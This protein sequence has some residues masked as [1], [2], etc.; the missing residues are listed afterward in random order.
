MGL[1]LKKIVKGVKKVAK[2]VVKPVGKVL[3]KG[4]S[5]VGNFVPGPLGSALKV[6]GSVLQGNNRQEHLKALIGSLVPGVG[7]K[8]VGQAGKFIGG[9]LPL[10]ALEN[11]IQ[12]IGGKIP[13]LPK[14][15]LPG[16]V[17][18]I[19][20]N[21]FAGGGTPGADAGGF[22]LP[23][24]KDLLI[25]GGVAYAGARGLKG[26]N[27]A[28]DA[29]NDARGERAGMARELASHGREL[30]QGARP[31]TA[32][33]TQALTKRLQDGQR[34][35]PDLGHLRDRANPFS[36]GF[37]P[38]VPPPPPTLALPGGAPAGPPAPN[39][40]QLPAPPRRKMLPRMPHTRPALAP[41]SY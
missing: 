25:G 17:D 16:G 38:R 5:L 40:P 37:A 30:M 12:G 6:G 26:A 36:Q 10:G 39:T 31:I 2:K 14:M 22:K 13:G 3:G 20:K 15:S 7:G 27:R 11:I 29:A 24:L 1:S 35:V 9:K 33:A 23:S 32:A 18:D 21:I 8:L 34:A 4:A 41:P 19:F 28:S